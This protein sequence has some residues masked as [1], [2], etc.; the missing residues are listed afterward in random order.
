MY[1]IKYVHN[2][3]C[4][5]MIY[6]YTYLQYIYI[7]IYNIYI[8]IYIYTVY[9]YIYIYIQCIYIYTVYIYIQYIYIYTVYIYTQYIY[10][11]Y[12]Y[13]YTVYIYTHKCAVYEFIG[14]N[15]VWWTCWVCLNMGYT[16]NL[17]GS[18]FSDK[19]KQVNQN[20]SSG[21]MDWR[22]CH[23]LGATWEPSWF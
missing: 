2:I 7:F 15:G 8:Y 4:I 14:F 10:I 16:S 9:I 13:I 12:I 18:I 20:G 1:I 17:R 23:W 3:R 11:Q 5:I 22:F 19:Q 6:I 21:R